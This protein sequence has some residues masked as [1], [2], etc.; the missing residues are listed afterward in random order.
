MSAPKDGGPAYPQHGWSSNPETVAR[1]SS[2]SGLSKLDYFAAAATDQDVDS[3]LIGNTWAAQ[4]GGTIH[5]RISARWAF[6]EAMLAESIKRGGG[7]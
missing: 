4:T 3:F 6:A 5:S 7:A 2:N 1:M